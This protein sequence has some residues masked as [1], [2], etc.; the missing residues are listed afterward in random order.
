MLWLHSFYPDLD[1]DLDV[2][3]T[4][5]LVTVGGR[6]AVDVGSTAGIFESLAA[7]DGSVVWSRRVDQGTAVHG[8]IG[9]PSS[10]GATIF[11]PSA[12][13][14]TGI[15]ALIGGSALWSVPTALPVYGSPALGDQVLITGTGAVFGDRSA[16]EL[17]ALSTEDGT[18]L[19]R[20]NAG[21]AINSSPAID[22]T[23]V[24]AGDFAGELLAFA[25]R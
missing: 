12:S 13:P 19:W 15:A 5:V 10:D 22:G 25:A 24:L 7:A 9:S 23:L 8:L 20:Y 2:G 21:S 4:P 3:A 1:R 6:E 17:L 16:G 18:I 11:Q 14:P